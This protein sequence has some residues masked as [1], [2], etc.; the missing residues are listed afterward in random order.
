M[1][2]FRCFR[3]IRDWFLVVAVM[4]M[5]M[6][7]AP[8]A[9]AGEDTIYVANVAST[10]LFRDMWVGP[11][12][13]PFTAD[14]VA[15]A[16]SANFFST[17]SGIWFD[18]DGDGIQDFD[19]DN[20]GILDT[21][22]E[23][24]TAV[25][26]STAGNADIPYV[27][28]QIS[29][30]GK[31]GM[32]YSSYPQFGQFSPDR[33]K[34]RTHHAYNGNE[35]VRGLA[36]LGGVATAE[37]PAPTGANDADIEAWYSENRSKEFRF[38]SR[39]T[40]TRQN[41][42]NAPVPFTYNNDRADQWPFTQGMSKYSYRH[43]NNLMFRQVYTKTPGAW[44]PRDAAHDF[45]VDDDGIPD[46]PS[47]WDFADPSDVEFG[48]LQHAQ[49]SAA[50]SG[51]FDNDDTGGQGAY[52]CQND[53]IRPQRTEYR[54]LLI[55]LADIAG[56]AD[57][58]LTDPFGWGGAGFDMAVYVRDSLG[59]VLSSMDLSTIGGNSGCGAAGSNPVDG[60]PTH[61]M[62]EQT[63]LNISILPN[64]AAFTH[65]PG[66]DDLAARPRFRGLDNTTPAAEEWPFVNGGF[67]TQRN[68]DFFNAL[69]S[70]YQIN[71]LQVADTT[72]MLGG[73]PATSSIVSTGAN[74]GTLQDP[75]FNCMARGGDCPTNSV[76]RTSTVFLLYNNSTVPI[77]NQ[78]PFTTTPADNTPRNLW[79]LDNFMRR[80][81]STGQ[82]RHIEDHSQSLGRYVRFP[83]EGDRT[84]GVRY[85]GVNVDD[86][87]NNADDFSLRGTP[88]SGTRG[89]AGGEDLAIAAR[90]WGIATG[91]TRTNDLCGGD[92]HRVVFT[93]RQ[94][95]LELPPSGGTELDSRETVIK[96]YR[97]AW[98]VNGSTISSVSIAYTG[99]TNAVQKHIALDTFYAA[100]ELATLNNPTP[101]LQFVVETGTGNLRDAWRTG[102]PHVGREHMLTPCWTPGT[103]AE[104]TRLEDPQPLEGDRIPTQQMILKFVPVG[105]S[106]D[107]SS[108][109]APPGA[110]EK[111]IVWAEIA[112]DGTTSI[113]WGGTL[114]DR[115]VAINPT[116]STAGALS[117]V[118]DA[119][120][121]L[122]TRYVLLFDGTNA[123]LFEAE[124]GIAGGGDYIKE[125]F[126]DLGGLGYTLLAGSSRPFV[127]GDVN[128]DGTR[129]IADP[130]TI[131]NFLFGGASDSVTC[132][133]S[134]D[135]ND[136]GGV[137]I[138]DP[139]SELNFLFAGGA[140]ISAPSPGCGIDPTA[141]GLSC[142]NFTPC[143][144]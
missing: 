37:P 78:D 6:A 30:G 52:S 97:D 20:D 46:A 16:P 121:E 82:E 74:P 17:L 15:S 33:T 69:Y 100:Q 41:G 123:E 34:I 133:K 18:L 115:G 76:L 39:E 139:I 47:D 70:S 138:A 116:A 109:T 40:Q 106:G 92:L 36:T 130:V 142:L 45:D 114:N 8:E 111:A 53:H 96:R 4:L 99:A 87:V 26:A 68:C 86:G 143:G 110:D 64:N 80:G 89:W 131:L 13:L 9:R 72:V 104:D 58:S 29:D 51:D 3:V 135:I 24:G 103:E 22:D 55:P 28:A 113:N 141:D 85:D 129:N 65:W 63:E 27:A 112:D 35:F 23:V 31:K 57:G 120:L 94:G 60:P 144:V 84:I 118:G 5:G 44:V 132:L 43:K 77:G 62:I 88:Q 107:G 14:D 124:D 122:Y 71:K 48:T 83:L 10:P 136:D 59:P 81:G 117:F 2:R 67:T 75:W 134:A 7:I 42:G 66:V 1:S 56:L 25:G 140:P 98:D 119:E 137:N 32:H 79:A 19:T 102:S 73:N 101:N 38:G 54:G 61:I 127:R 126:D 21:G 90:G 128:R 125:S 105:G 49:G 95:S 91:P 11:D 50:I 108:I 93:C 12:L